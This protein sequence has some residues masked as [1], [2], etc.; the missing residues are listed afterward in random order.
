MNEAE[1]QKRL[2]VS[3]ELEEIVAQKTATYEKL[4]NALEAEIIERVALEE[5]ISRGKREW[6]A[7]FDSLFDM[8]LVTDEQGR[9]VRCNK[10]G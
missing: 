10:A 1:Q 7:I 4:I 2:R 9:I 5:T 8:L 6:E 3:E